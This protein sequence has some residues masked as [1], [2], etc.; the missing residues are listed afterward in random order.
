MH[1]H[2]WPYPWPHKHS[3]CGQHMARRPPAQHLAIHNIAVGAALTTQT[4][5]QHI[6]AHH[7]RCSLCARGLDTHEDCCAAACHKQ[8]SIT[9]VLRTTIMI[10]VLTSA[11]TR[12]GDE[13]ASSRGSRT[14]SKPC[15]MHVCTYTSLTC[16]VSGCYSAYPASSDI[17]HMPLTPNLNDNA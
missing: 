7:H 4:A 1:C 10:E 16:A 17:M 13:G 6:H 12:G 8:N 14:C 15:I 2:A 11:Q 9:A 5:T 3:T